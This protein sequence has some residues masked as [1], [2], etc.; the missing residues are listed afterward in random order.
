PIDNGRGS[1]GDA[2]NTRDFVVLH[3]AAR[4]ATIGIN[5]MNSLP[6]GLGSEAQNARAHSFARFVQGVAYG[7]LALAYD[8]A[9]LLGD[10]D[11]LLA[12]QPLSDYKVMMAQALVML[13]SAI[14]IARAAPASFPLPATW[15]AGHDPANATRLDTTA[16]FQWIRSY[17]A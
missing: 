1:T 5:A 6:N 7:N 10:N 4:M 14:T 8:S 15:V 16:Y 11:D 13:D 2:G 3:R 9:S 17:K 12:I